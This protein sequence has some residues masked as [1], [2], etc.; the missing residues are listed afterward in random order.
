ML[1]RQGDAKHRAGQHRCNGAF[2]LDRL[3]SIHIIGWAREAAPNIFAAA[4]PSILSAI[5]SKRTIS[6]IEAR[7]FIAR[8]R[9]V[10]FQA[11]TI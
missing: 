9:F 10:H 11:A 4:P 2:Q 1:V 6:V 7:T 8:A 3:V 5:P